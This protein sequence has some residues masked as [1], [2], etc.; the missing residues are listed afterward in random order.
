MNHCVKRAFD[1]LALLFS[2]DD[3]VIEMFV[4]QKLSTSVVCNII[5]F[6]VNMHYYFIQFDLT[7]AFFLRGH[8]LHVCLELGNPRRKH[9][10]IFSQTK[11]GR[12]PRI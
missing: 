5:H 8:E 10:L 12:L 11:Q 6:I 9:V 3:C 7:A 1:F 4:K 2:L